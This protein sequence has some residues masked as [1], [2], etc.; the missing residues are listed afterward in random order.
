MQKQ[1]KKTILKAIGFSLFMTIIIFLN[2]E[3]PKPNTAI[4]LLFVGVI[5][6]TSFCVIKFITS[7]AF[8]RFLEKTENFS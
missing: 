2:V 4:Y 3:N 8:K 5:S 6:F 7:K 1:R